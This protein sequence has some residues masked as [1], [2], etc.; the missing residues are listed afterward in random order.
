M[1]PSHVVVRRRRHG[2]Q[3]AHRVYPGF[4]TFFIDCWKSL[5]KRLADT[6]TAIKKSTPATHVFLVNS[7]GDDVARCEFRVRMNSGHKTLAPAIDEQRA[8]TAQGLGSERSGIGVDIDG[9]RMKLNEFR[10][11][12]DGPRAR[13]DGQN[14]AIT[15]SRV[16]RTALNY[17]KI[18]ARIV[19]GLK[20]KPVGLARQFARVAQQIRKLMSQHVGVVRHADGLELALGQ[21]DDIAAKY[22]AQPQLRNM[23]EAA[24]IVTIAALVRTE[25]RGA[26]FRADFPKAH[27]TTWQRRSYLSR[28]DLTPARVTALLAERAHKHPRLELIAGE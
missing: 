6:A 7:A 15:H 8:F 12:N 5:G 20:P 17:Q 25:S 4:H 14:F 24:R 9:G 19:R 28:P 13:C 11:R 10:V 2:N 18:G 1:H 21:F 16:C 26:H 23:A 27:P 3:I 22:A